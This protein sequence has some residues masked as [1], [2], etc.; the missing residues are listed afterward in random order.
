MYASVAR[1][2]SNVRKLCTGKPS[3]PSLVESLAFAWSERRALATGEGRA[4]RAS[5]TYSSSNSIGFNFS[6]MCHSM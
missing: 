2:S 4:V 3:S 5:S 1:S 6:R